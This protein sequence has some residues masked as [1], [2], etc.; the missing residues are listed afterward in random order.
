MLVY[1]FLTYM[2]LGAVP[3]RSSLDYI[4]ITYNKGKKENWPNFLYVKET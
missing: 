4:T 1:L 2:V 3:V